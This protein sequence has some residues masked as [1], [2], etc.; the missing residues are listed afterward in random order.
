MFAGS[1]FAAAGPLTLPGLEIAGSATFVAGT[2]TASGALT[3]PGLE[4][5][6]SGTSDIQFTATG[7]LT[8][9]GLEVA[10][11]GTTSPEGQRT[12]TGALALPGL[13]I[14]GTATF[15]SAASLVGT[16]AGAGWDPG[17]RPVTGT[18]RLDKRFH[19]LDRL[20][21]RQRERRLSRATYRMRWR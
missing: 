20:A 13:E 1:I 12:G 18:G 7:A 9:P 21:N 4:L 16:G 15:T 6:G 10:G 14:S 17:G 8:L 11:T 19:F 5:V 3:L 2:F